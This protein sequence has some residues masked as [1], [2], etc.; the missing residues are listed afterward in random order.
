MVLGTSV[1]AAV[2]F[3]RVNLGNVGEVRD[4]WLAGFCMFCQ[5]LRHDGVDTAFKF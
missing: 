3:G 1:F 4:R 5:F 2:G